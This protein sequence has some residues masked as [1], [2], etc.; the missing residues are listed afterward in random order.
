MSNPTKIFLHRINPAKNE[1]RFYLVEATPTLLDPY[2]VIRVWGRIGG[3]QR[4][5]IN[6]CRSAAEAEELAERLVRR[7]IKRG[8][9]VVIWRRPNDVYWSNRRRQTIYS[10]A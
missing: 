2:A 1:A 8:Y 7:K 6:P 4:H 5:K 9:K 3:A 10:A